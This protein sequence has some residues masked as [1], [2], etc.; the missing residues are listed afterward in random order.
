M[1]TKYYPLLTQISD[2]TFHVPNSRNTFTLS[3][4]GGKL[5]SFGK[6]VDNEHPLIPVLFQIDNKVDWI[7]GSFVE[8]FIRT[9]GEKLSVVVP[10]K[11]IIE[12]MGNY[13]VYVQLTPE[14]FEKRQVSVGKTDGN[15]TE[16]LSGLDGSERV[17][18]DGSI[19]VKIM[20]SAGGLD[21]ESGHQH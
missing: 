7:P 18:T 10:Q 5:V 15:F 11:S 9:S 8:L 13:F 17:V 12:E 6:S 2:V 21:A 3:D 19:L 16:I 1:Q 14:Y 20:Q 4:L